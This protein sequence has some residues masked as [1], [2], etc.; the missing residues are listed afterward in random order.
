MRQTT[1]NLPLLC[2]LTYDIDLIVCCAVHST[3]NN[4]YIALINCRCSLLSVLQK[5]MYM[6]GQ[7]PHGRN[8]KSGS[9]LKS[10]NLY[11]FFVSEQKQQYHDLEE[12]PSLYDPNTTKVSWYEAYPGASQTRVQK[13][14]GCRGSNSISQKTVHI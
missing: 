1:K 3:G 13:M 12:E 14:H 4:S 10:V 2:V 7:K 6:P 5:K 11:L 9:W 8:W